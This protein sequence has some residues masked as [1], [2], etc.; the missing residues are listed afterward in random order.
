MDPLPQRNLLPI[1]TM[2][3]ETAEVETIVEA[4][5]HAVEAAF[6]PAPLKIPLQEI[7]FTA[8]KP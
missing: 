1:I 5:A 7:V 8:F 3:S 6:G 4:V 2:G